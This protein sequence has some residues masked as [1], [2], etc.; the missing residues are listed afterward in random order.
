MEIFGKKFNRKDYLSNQIN[1]SEDK[2]EYCKTFEG[3]IQFFK[4]NYLC[5][6]FG[7]EFKFIV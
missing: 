4:S 2:F 7:S 1:R 5:V 3:T 6:G